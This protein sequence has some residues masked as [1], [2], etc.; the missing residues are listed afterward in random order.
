LE[1]DR[2][3]AHLPMMAEN[4]HI[5][6]HTRHTLLVEHLASRCRQWASVTLQPLPQNDRDQPTKNDRFKPTHFLVYYLQRLFIWGEWSIAS[7]RYYHQR[8]LARYERYQAQQKR[9]AEHT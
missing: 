1:C 9:D 4:G 7:A 3:K 6:P 2:P 5:L 8:E